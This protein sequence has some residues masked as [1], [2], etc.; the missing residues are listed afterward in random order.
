[1]D[2]ILIYDTYHPRPL[3][4]A[5]NLH[6]ASLTDCDW[7]CDGRCLVVCSTDGYVS[8]LSFE[9]GELGVLYKCPNVTTI[10]ITPVPNPPALNSTTI[11]AATSDNAVNVSMV[12]TDNNNTPK[13]KNNNEVSLTVTKEQSMDAATAA[14][15][16][17]NSVT[18]P[19]PS[20]KARMMETIPIPVVS[21]I[22]AVEVVSPLLKS[23]PFT[24][25]N[26]GN[27]NNNIP[28]K[29]NGKKRRIVL[30]PVTTTTI[31]TAISS[32][33]LSNDIN[34]EKGV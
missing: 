8:V 7:T 3:S 2:T 19:S 21:K 27:N 6:Y 20:K 18:L 22:A 14:V 33:P 24:T 12:I 31:A 17:K 34:G 4:I 16:E 23:Q 25:T 9:E 29:K 13:N 32:L 11:T 15:A 26:K 5:K 30:T 28:L 1:M 10:S